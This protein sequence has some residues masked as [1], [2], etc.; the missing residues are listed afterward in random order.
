M[1]SSLEQWV[2]TAILPPV[3]YVT[4]EQV[5]PSTV[6]MDVYTAPEG[7]G[8]PLTAQLDF[9][10]NDLRPMVE[11]SFIKIQVKPLFEK[12]AWLDHL[13]ALAQENAIPVPSSTLIRPSIT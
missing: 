11:A 2:A 5:T 3:V 1:T 12:Q 10:D 13:Q 9:A 8:R 6:R 4:F 7:Q